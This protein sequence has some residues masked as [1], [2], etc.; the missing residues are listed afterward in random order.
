MEEKKKK[1]GGTLLPRKS[2]LLVATTDDMPQ[3][4]IGFYVTIFSNVLCSP[5]TIS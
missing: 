1:G 3:C 4:S 2:V 5:D